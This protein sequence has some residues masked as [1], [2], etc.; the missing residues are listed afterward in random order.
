MMDNNKNFLPYG[1]HEILEED[2]QNVSNV[3]RN[4]NL[5]QGEYVPNFE[6]NLAKKV[7]SKYCIAVNS[8]TSALH[9]ACISQLEP[10]K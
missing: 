1:K 5:T 3:L 9:I 8:A 10:A 4:K 7:N 6:N 2:I